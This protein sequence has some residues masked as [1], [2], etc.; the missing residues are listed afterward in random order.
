M[1]ISNSIN[2]LFLIGKRYF[3]KSRKARHR[4]EASNPTS[5]FDSMFRISPEL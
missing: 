5:L 4:T 1:N 3:M 2:L